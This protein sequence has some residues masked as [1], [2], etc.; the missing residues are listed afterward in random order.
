MNYM[1]TICTKKDI[2]IIRT[3]ILNII[4]ISFVNRYKRRKNER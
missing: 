3:F 4:G 2:G 1:F